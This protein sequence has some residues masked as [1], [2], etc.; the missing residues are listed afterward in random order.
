MSSNW[1]LRWRKPAVAELARLLATVSR[2]ACCA[3]IPLAA[4]YNARIIVRSLVCCLA[5]GSLALGLIHEFGARLIQRVVCI[6]VVPAQN[7]RLAVP[8]LVF[9]QVLG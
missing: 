8:Y 7:Q 5:C 4:V 3:L 1:S 6:D 2:L 9:A